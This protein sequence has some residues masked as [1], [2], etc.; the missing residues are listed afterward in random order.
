MSTDTDTDMDR[1]ISL[2]WAIMTHAR[3]RE[4]AERLAGLCSEPAP[5]VVEDPGAGSTIVTSAA[6]WATAAGASHHIVLQD[7]ALPVEGLAARV[8]D[9]VSRA[10]DAAISLFTEWGCRT[11]TRVR[12]AALAGEATAP[13]VD[14]Y[15]PSLALV[16]PTP[17][18]L[19]FAEHAR[20]LDPATPDDVALRG[21]LNDRGVRQLVSVPNLV[22][23]DTN[24]TTPSLTGN[25]F[26]G[27]RRSVCF[28]PPPR[29]EE[30]VSSG[31]APRLAHIGWMRATAEVFDDSPQAPPAFVGTPVAQALPEQVE[32]ALL[33][34][35]FEETITRVAREHG[36][37]LTRLL[38]R[39]VLF[40]LWTV[41][42]ANGLGSGLRAEHLERGRLDPVAEAALGTVLP[43]VF[44]RY[45]P[46]ETLETVRDHTV[47]F[48][49]DAMR[50]G[51]AEPTEVREEWLKG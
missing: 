5:T 1:G 12:I 43:G 39:T 44:R 16:L 17:V 37:E 40:E 34:E 22:E 50:Y 19:A 35:R 25:A 36:P 49:L 23:H 11:A 47:T 46:V 9:L 3:R 38:H 2:T 18:A 7:D 29:A 4:H 15:V 13:V 31:S 42:Y 26:Q 14:P 51:A 28:G 6:A 48:V 30:N 8:V 32:P 45:V 20:G 21:F 41:W 10:P 24:G 27:V 33:A